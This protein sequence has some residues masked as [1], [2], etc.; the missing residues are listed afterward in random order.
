MIQA[1]LEKIFLFRWRRP[2]S[3]RALARRGKNL[4][5]R[6]QRKGLCTFGGGPRFCPGRQLAMMEI[7][8]VM[9]MLCTSFE[10][11]KTET[12]SAVNEVFSFTM[13][14]EIRSRPASK[15]SMAQSPSPPVRVCSTRGNWRGQ[16]NWGS[17]P[18]ETSNW[19]KRTELPPSQDQFFAPLIAS[20]GF[21]RA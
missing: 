17:T 10:L 4:G 20:A 19:R 14:P 8:T 13:T 7:K 21:G 6:A 9:A 16:H 3:A 12:A 1:H 5:L 18:L 11:S 2:V 15:P